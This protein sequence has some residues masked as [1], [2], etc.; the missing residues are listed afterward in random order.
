ML[1]IKDLKIFFI[2]PNISVDMRGFNS[3]STVGEWAKR[4]Y[5]LKIEYMIC[6][7]R[8]KSWIHPKMLEGSWEGRDVR[9]GG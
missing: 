6:L 4:Y 2:W 9:M 7:E 3:L 1:L 8:S 5:P